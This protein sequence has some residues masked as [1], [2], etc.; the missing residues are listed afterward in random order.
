M[1]VFRLL[2]TVASR[3][4]HRRDVYA[5]TMA[6]LDAARGRNAC[7]YPGRSWLGDVEPFFGRALPRSCARFVRSSRAP[8]HGRRSVMRPQI[9]DN[10]PAISYYRIDGTIFGFL[11][12]KT[13]I[14]RQ[15]LD[16]ML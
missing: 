7:D 2:G 3:L 9:G 5:G 6:W 16:L 10:R 14:R 1:G 12:D 11:L 8:N 13:E 15:R 4:C